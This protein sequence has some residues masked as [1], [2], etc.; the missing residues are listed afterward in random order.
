M[1]KQ[2]HSKRLT[3]TF[4]SD[5]LFKML[6]SKNQNLLK[7]LVSVIL[8]I[9]PESIAEFVV[10]NSEIA[11]EE[12]ETKFC[13]IDIRMRV[14]EELVS[15]EIQ[16][17][18]RG[19]YPER[20]LYY[21]AR[22]FSSALL[23]GEDYIRLPKTILIS[24][25]GFTLFKGNEVHSEFMAMEVNRHEPLTDKMS[26]H[27]FELPKLTGYDAKDELS[28]WLA[29]FDAE[30]EG[31]LNQLL[32]LEVDFVKQAVQAY[33][34]IT[35]DEKFREMERKREMQRHD[36]ASALGHARRMGASEEREK[37][38]L[39]VSGKE[40]ELSEKEAVISE[41]DAVISEKVEE[42][43]KKEAEIAKLHA[44]LETF[45]KKN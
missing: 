11:P 37:W 1:K 12:I 22:E 34:T 35:A 7:R 4:K 40:A 18:N 26:L 9:N 17:E 45:R 24:I 27:Y 36:E 3:Y 31:E 43:S 10:T 33:R 29:L 19:N 23:T 5:I 20:T 8:K 28:L 2:E 38:Q 30:T 6:F 14:N 13:R 15:L 39:V 32:E 44:E 16:V 21:W 25:L 42:L 41:R